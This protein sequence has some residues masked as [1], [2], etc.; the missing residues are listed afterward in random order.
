MLIDKVKSNINSDIKELNYLC[1]EGLSLSKKATIERVKENLDKPPLNE[2]TKPKLKQDELLLFIQLLRDKNII[3]NKLASS[4]T[5]IALL[6]SYLTGYSLERIRQKIS[7]PTL[8]DISKKKNTTS[9][10]LRLS[11]TSLTPWKGS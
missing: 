1:K 3:T 6:F 10:L 11:M 5:D 4:K 8:Q 9:T 2:M 7:K